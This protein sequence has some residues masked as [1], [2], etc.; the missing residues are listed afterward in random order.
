MP[1]GLRGEKRVGRLALLLTAAAVILGIGSVGLFFYALGHP[2][3]ISIL[4]FGFNTLI[5]LGVI[6]MAIGVW[7]RRAQ[8]S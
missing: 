7:R 4:R 6:L 8:G 5:A 3:E 1:R 2:H